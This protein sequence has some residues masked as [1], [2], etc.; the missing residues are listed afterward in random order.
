MLE[1][2]QVRLTVAIADGGVAVALL[3]GAGVWHLAATSATL[4]S[5][6]LSLVCWPGSLFGVPINLTILLLLCRTRR[7]E[8]ARPRLI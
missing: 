1:P 2:D 5:L 6:A 7:S 8:W 4:A 3:R